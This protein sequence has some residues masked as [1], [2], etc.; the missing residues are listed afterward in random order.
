[1]ACLAGSFLWR[2]ARARHADTQC[3]AIVQAVRA[4]PGFSQIQVRPRRRPGDLAVTGTV[5]TE[6]QFLSLT[7]LLVTYAS[8]LSIQVWI[9]YP[10]GPAPNGVPNRTVVTHVG[11]RGTYD[12]LGDVL[13][14]ARLTAFSVF[15]YVFASSLFGALRSKIGTSKTANFAVLIP[16]PFLIITLAFLTFWHLP[17]KVSPG[18]PWLV[19][20]TFACSTGLLTHSM[21]TLRQG[22]Y[23]LLSAVS[24]AASFLIVVPSCLILAIMIAWCLLPTWFA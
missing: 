17:S 10:A 7:R 9:E 24:L 21:A 20:L 16:A 8:D 4:V 3:Q 13:S 11:E 2:A 12:M 14:F 22:P 23:R 6:E 15:L 1:M 19:P 5:Q 18:H